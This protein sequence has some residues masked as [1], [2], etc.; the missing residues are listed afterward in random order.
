VD[1]SSSVDYTVDTRAVV[2]MPTS[3]PPR[4]LFVYGTLLPGLAPP[5]IADI[6]NTLCLAGPATVAGRLYH[7]GA[8]PGCTLHSDCETQIQGTLLELPPDNEPILEKL[9]WYEGYAAHDEH[10]SLFLRTTCDATTPDGRQLRAWVY[11][12]NRDVSRAR[13]IPTGR[14]HPDQT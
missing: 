11:V 1:V 8:Y 6:V 14:Y 2:E 7:F 9:D 4:Y 13:L 3:P 12:Y 5:V 10:G